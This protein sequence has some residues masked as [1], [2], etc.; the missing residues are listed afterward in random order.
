MNAIE[1][2]SAE[3]IIYIAIKLNMPPESEYAIEK[4]FPNKK[5]V[6][7]I[8]SILIKKASCGDMQYIIHT[9]KRFESPSFVPGTQKNAGSRLSI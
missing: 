1:K 5:P 9:T 8:L 3:K 6:K 2:I 7:I 4:V